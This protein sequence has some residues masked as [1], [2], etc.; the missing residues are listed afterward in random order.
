[1]AVGIAKAMAVTVAVTVAVAV[2]VGFIGFCA[3]IHTHQEIIG[4][5]YAGFIFKYTRVTIEHKFG[6]NKPNIA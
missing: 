6:L 1:M 5:L 3:T 4:L 2:A